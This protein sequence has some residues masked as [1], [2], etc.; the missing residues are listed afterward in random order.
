MCA[1]VTREFQKKKGPSHKPGILRLPEHNTVYDGPGA[2]PDRLAALQENRC[3]ISSTCRRTQYGHI[4]C[5][6]RRNDNA[7]L[8]ANKN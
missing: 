8:N 5:T 4:L 6:C 7:V 1:S 2:G 3:T